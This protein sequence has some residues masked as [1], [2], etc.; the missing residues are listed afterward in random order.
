[1]DTNRGVSILIIENRGPMIDYYQ[2][3]KQQYQNIHSDSSELF[4]AILQS[5]KEIGM[6]RALAELKR[7][8]LIIESLG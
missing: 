7:V 3:I 4:N 2:R 5:S 8:Q 6:D 1:M